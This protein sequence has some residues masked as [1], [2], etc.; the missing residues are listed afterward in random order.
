I[1]WAREINHH[2]D[3]LAREYM[4]ASPSGHSAFRLF[5]RESEMLGGSTYGP[6]ALCFGG[7]E[8]EHLLSTLSAVIEVHHVDGH[9]RFGDIQ[10][11]SGSADFD[12]AALEA[13]EFVASFARKEALQFNRATKSSTW[14]FTAN[15]YRWGMGD[16]AAD[17]LFDAPGEVFDRKLHWIYTQDTKVELVSLFPDPRLDPELYDLK[18]VADS[19]TPAAPR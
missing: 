15:V 10:K 16:F 14:R 17:P 5:F 2:D 7:C 1:D 13:V 11:T 6:I 4:S 18:G 19:N 12:R 8:A 9:V 3:L